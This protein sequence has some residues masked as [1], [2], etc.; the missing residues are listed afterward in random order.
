MAAYFFVV[1]N[2]SVI[3]FIELFPIVY[4]F[5]HLSGK[6]TEIC[7]GKVSHGHIEYAHIDF[8]LP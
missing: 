6:K 5:I 2:T 7:K 8:H 1:L 4:Q 3:Y